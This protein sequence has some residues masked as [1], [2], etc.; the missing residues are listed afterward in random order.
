[1]LCPGDAHRKPEGGQG[2]RQSP[3]P[4]LLPGSRR[5]D[6]LQFTAGPQKP[7]PQG[8]QLLPQPPERLPR[9]HT[10][11]QP[12]SQ[13]PQIIQDIVQHSGAVPVTAQKVQ[14]K[15]N[16]VQ[17]Q[18]LPQP[19][20]LRKA[21]DVVVGGTRQAD[22]P[23]PPEGL[24]L[25][26]S[27]PVQRDLLRLPAEFLQQELQLLPLQCPAAICL[28]RNGAALVPA[29]VLLW[30]GAKALFK[31]VAEIFVLGKAAFVGDGLEPLAPLQ[32]HGRRLL[33]T[34][35]V[36]E[37]PEAHAAAVLENVGQV[38]GADVLHGRHILN[39]DRLVVVAVDV[40]RDPADAPEL[41]LV[42]LVGVVELGKAAAQIIALELLDESVE[43]LLP[44][45]PVGSRLRPRPVQQ[46]GELL[47]QIAAQH[48]D[49]RG[50]VLQGTVGKLVG[51]QVRK[52]RPVCLHI[53]VQQH[54]RPPGVGIGAEPV[55]LPRTAHVNI[56]GLHVQHVVDHCELKG[57]LQGKH[58][59]QNVVVHMK[60]VFLHLHD[61]AL[62]RRIVGKRDCL[63]QHV[64]S[65][66]SVVL[67]LR[68]CHGQPFG[69]YF[70]VFSNCFPAK[71]GFHSVSLSA[72]F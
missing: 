11:P 50:I 38:V 14:I 28:H 59:L 2:L 18:L 49:S 72:C 32:Q 41:E 51:P 46:P 30:R 70:T 43:N 15:R 48:L 16:G 36:Q 69:G 63:I 20:Q 3:G 9:R 52:L 68:G 7:L 65:V 26:P 71:S 56:P 39:A 21:G 42:S 35:H 4:L 66:L 45:L 40:V 53:D 8:L 33:H 22:A 54:H 64:P 58:D 24:L 25:I 34:G 5:N 44:H 62:Q 6:H 47:F 60:G 55:Q 31:A 10:D 29:P 23:G 27:A 19:P 12:H 67:R 13:R 61:T 17:P 37:G 57:A 1:M